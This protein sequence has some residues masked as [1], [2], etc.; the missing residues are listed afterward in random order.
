MDALICAIRRL[1]PTQV[2]LLV[3]HTKVSDEHF[4]RFGGVED[5][6]V[7][8]TDTGLSDDEADRFREAGL[9]VRVA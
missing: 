7:L 5:V 9:Q 3:D 6:D 8:V 1:P 2:V 4:V